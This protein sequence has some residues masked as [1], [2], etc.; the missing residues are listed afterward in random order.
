MC[1]IVCS[2]LL[3]RNFCVCERRKGI[4]RRCCLLCVQ[5]YVSAG[6]ILFG[7]VPRHALTFSIQFGK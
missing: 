6:T 5:K 3:L 1:R 7:A 2:V 4:K